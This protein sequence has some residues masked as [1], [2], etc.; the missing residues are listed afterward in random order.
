MS[1]PGL[2]LLSMAL[3]DQCNSVGQGRVKPTQ[4]LVEFAFYLMYAVTSVAKKNTQEVA[5]S[6][7]KSC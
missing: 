1:P 7:L 3:S 4:P 6:A 5:F 2:L